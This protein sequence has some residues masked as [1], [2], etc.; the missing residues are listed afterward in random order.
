M[1]FIVG[2]TGNIN[3]P[4]QS[5]A[6]EPDKLQATTGESESTQTTTRDPDTPTLVLP[7]HCPK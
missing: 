2:H 6:V 7:N 3:V 4:I 5:A 1:V